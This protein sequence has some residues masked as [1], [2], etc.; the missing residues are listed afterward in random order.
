M[1]NISYYLAHN[2]EVTV[3]TI[4]ESLAKVISYDGFAYE[5]EEF[6]TN[7]LRLITEDQIVTVLVNMD[8]CPSF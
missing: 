7:N 4:F 1:K 3:E 5:V 6:E 2:Y 8:T